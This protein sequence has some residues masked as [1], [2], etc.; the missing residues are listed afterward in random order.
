MPPNGS[1]PTP[2]VP[3]VPPMPTAGE[4]ASVEADQLAEQTAPT[5]EV[6]AV[7]AT[8]AGTEVQA[9]GLDSEDL[10]VPPMFKPAETVAIGGPGS[11]ESSNMMAAAARATANGLAAGVTRNEP[12]DPN[13]QILPPPP[14]IVPPTEAV[15]AA[16]KIVDLPPLP[17]PPAA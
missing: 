12:G 11:E 3:P 10:K 16:E 2:E 1:T 6:P 14:E 15:Q 7:E 17:P 5:P 4:Q 8:P 9:S 13:M